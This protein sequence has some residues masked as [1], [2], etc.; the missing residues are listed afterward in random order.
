MCAKFSTDNEHTIKQFKYVDG[1]CLFNGMFLYFV[2]CPICFK[3]PSFNMASCPYCTRAVI[4]FY[5]LSSTIFHSKSTFVFLFL[6]SQRDGKTQKSDTIYHWLLIFVI[7]STLW[8]VCPR[9]YEIYTAK[10]ISNIKLHF[11]KCWER[12]SRTIHTGPK[13]PIQSGQ[14]LLKT[15]YRIHKKGVV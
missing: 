14:K 6:F 13:G 2:Y 9:F 7:V 1:C 8:M 11:L 5:E 3:R 15:F 10:Q 12:K 4:D